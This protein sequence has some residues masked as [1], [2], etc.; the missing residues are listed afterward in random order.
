MSINDINANSLLQE[1]GVSKVQ[2]KKDRN[3]LGQAE[4]MDLMVAQLRNQDPFKPLENGDFIAQMAQFSAV[5][6]LEELQGSFDTLATSLQSNQA[7]QASTLVGRSVL[8]PSSEAVLNPGGNVRGILDLP[9]GTP[10]LSVS[11]LD[12]NGELVKRIQ[13]GSHG[14]GDAPFL[15]DGTNETGEPMPAGVYKFVAEAQGTDSRVAVDTFINAS[16]DSVTIGNGG[17]KLILNLKDM[18]QVDFSQVREI[19]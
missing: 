10:N 3:K 16:V 19:S 15:W 1:L 13:L 14:G 8:V 2:E 11:V 18:G 6:G 17:Q 4:F 9:Q 7:L 5:T 12:S